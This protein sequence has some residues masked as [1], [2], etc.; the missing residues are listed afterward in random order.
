MF[1][2]ADGLGRT[3]LLPSRTTNTANGTQRDPATLSKLYLPA[4]TVT[5]QPTLSSS[6]SN[7]VLLPT[8][9]TNLVPLSALATVERTTA[10]LA[11]MH[12]DQFPAVTMSFNLAPGASLGDAV[13]AIS[14]AENDVD[15]PASV[16]GTSTGKPRTLA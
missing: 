11:I 6:T 16:I 9:A 1:D 8:N 2:V 10:P 13:A 3:S 5:Q 14:V 12:Q 7:A 4:G 15:M